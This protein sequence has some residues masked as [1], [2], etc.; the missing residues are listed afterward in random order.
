MT[1]NYK[2]T[3]IGMIYTVICLLT[4]LTIIVPMLTILPL[5]L[6][7]ELVFSKIFGDGNYSKVGNSVLLSLTIIFFGC[8]TLFYKNFKQQLKQTNRISKG[9]FILFLSLQLIIVHPLIFYLNTSKDWSRASDGQFIFG[10]TE[11]FPISSFAFLIFGVIVDTLRNNSGD[12]Q[13]T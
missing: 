10:I 13:S 12:K 6:P 1:G 8:I 4:I 9:S 7:L 11:T 5:A 3:L 2:A